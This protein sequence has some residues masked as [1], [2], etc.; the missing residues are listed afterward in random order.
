MDAAV[1]PATAI[2]DVAAEAGGVQDGG[3][4]AVGRKGPAAA[5]NVEEE[6]VGRSPLVH[7]FHVSVVCLCPCLC[8]CAR[9]SACVYSSV[10]ACI[11]R[12]YMHSHTHACM[13]V[14]MQEVE[15]GA[16]DVTDSDEDSS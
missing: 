11:Q 14:H 6:E 4:R 7:G 16:E 8:V 12:A 10:L 2:L 9:A 5:A 15:E 13:H 1:T 3:V